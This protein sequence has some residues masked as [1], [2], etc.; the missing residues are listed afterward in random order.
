MRK[1]LASIVLLCMACLNA[2]CQKAEVHK[3]D[4]TT[5][6]I[7]VEDIDSITFSMTNPFNFETHTVRLNSGYDMPIIGIGTFYLSTAQA[8]ESVYNA[9]KVGMRLIDTADIYDNEVGVGR[10]IRRAMQDFGIKREEIFVTSKLWTSSFN[11]A[12]REVDERL[13]RLGLDYIDLLLLHHTA[14][15]DEE[16]YQAMERG[17]KAGKIRSIGL[18]NFYEDDIDRMMKIATVKPAVLQNETHPYHQSR[19]VKAHIAKMGTILE[20]WFPLGGR[21]TGI[22]TLSEHET[23]TSIAQVHN[24]S[25][26]QVLL[27]WHLQCGT[28]AIPGSS[29]AAHIA[30]D[31]DIFDFELT[32]DEMQRINALECNHRF[33]SY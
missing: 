10:G 9:L 6:E 26:Y 11:N 2:Q 14:P 4:G 3:N 15:Y 23:I 28:I 27:R 17:V 1:V 16:A 24:K 7:P 20:A 12:D 31:Y 33:A 29:N 25:A 5:V 30:E 21:G 18:S 22:K 8:E 32:P 19:S 13:E